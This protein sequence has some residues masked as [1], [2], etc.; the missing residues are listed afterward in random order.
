MITSFIQQTTAKVVLASAA[1]G[2]WVSGGGELA[3]DSAN[4]WFLDNTQQVSYCIAVDAEHFQADAAI[5][6]DSVAKAL[7]FWKRDFQHAGT[8]TSPVK[9]RVATQDFIRE[10]CSPT[11]DIRFQFGVLDKE[12]KAALPNVKDFVS[13]AVRTNY[14]RVKLR[15]KGFVYV[16]PDSGPLRPHLKNLGEQVW[17]RN[18][19]AALYAV[20]IHELGHVFGI[21]HSRDES[22]M[23]AKFPA[24][25]VEAENVDLAHVWTMNFRYFG[26]EGE[27]IQ[28]AL[29]SQSYS[30]FA[31]PRKAE[32][33]DIHLKENLL[34]VEAS[35]NGERVHIGSAKLS[36]SEIAIP[37]PIADIYLPPEQIAYLYPETGMDILRYVPGPFRKR[38]KFKGSYKDDEGK[39]SRPIIVSL[40]SDG[41]IERI[42]G[43]SDNTLYD[44]VLSGK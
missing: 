4:P 26:R 27:T 10:K 6:E 15:G 8:F 29:G 38:L 17:Q 9:M 28:R 35:F 3:N 31:I 19:G 36:L 43:V 37:E 21:P 32:S 25:I 40:G 34:S 30:F 20:L 13:F 18:E 44:D 7:A 5:I 41:T 14:D 12:Q 22:L 39:I 24:R 33:A 23:D 1:S 11:S 2:G 42:S 16:S